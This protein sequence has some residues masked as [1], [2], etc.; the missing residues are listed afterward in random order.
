[1]E[2]WLSLAY[3]AVVLALG[4]SS[5][6]PK[7]TQHFAPAS[8]QSAPTPSEVVNPLTP[9]PAAQALVT[10]KVSLNNA[11][12]AELESLPRVGPALAK[13]IMDGRPYQRIED[14]D[15]VR[16]VGPNMLEHLRP[17]VTL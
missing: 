3:I 13:R 12:Q 15:R 5:L 17:L 1:M 10:V 6:W 11:S 14:L 9:G 16:G 4:L 2:R 8:I 7:L